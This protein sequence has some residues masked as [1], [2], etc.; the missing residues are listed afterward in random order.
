M[1]SPRFPL[2]KAITFSGVG[3]LL[4]S[5]LGWSA[6]LPQ[7][8]TSHAVVL[9]QNNTSGTMN[10]DQ[11]AEL[12]SAIAEIRQ[13]LKEQEMALEDMKSAVERQIKGTEMVEKG[14]MHELEL[15]QSGWKSK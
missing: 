8:L 11:S 14:L 5:G 1:D 4:A 7:S 10:D 12:K 2:I 3:L 9:A 6:T 13:G 15:R